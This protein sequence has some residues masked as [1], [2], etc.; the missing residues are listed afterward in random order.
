[1]HYQY[2]YRMTRQALAGQLSPAALRLVIQGNLLQDNLVSNRFQP[3]RHFTEGRLAEALAYLEAERAAVV[4]ALHHGPNLG[5][6]WRAFGRL[7][8]TAQDFYAHTNYVYLWAGRYNDALPSPEKIEPLDPALLASPALHTVR[9]YAPLGYLAN[10]PL[11][12]RSIF[13]F[14]PPDAHARMSL[15]ANWSGPLFPY[16]MAAAIRRSAY[17]FNKTLELIGEP[18]LANQF[19]GKRAQLRGI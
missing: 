10:V 5:R 18:R 2:H 13:P 9:S 14:L 8:H 7:L 15:D 11:L 19:V 16:A 3:E 6:A 12:G 1:M 17:E 4:L